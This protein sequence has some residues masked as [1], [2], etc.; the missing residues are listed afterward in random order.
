MCTISIVHQTMA[1]AISATVGQTSVEGTVKFLFSKRKRLNVVV[2]HQLV[3]I[4][5]ICDT[6]GKRSIYIFYSFTKV[7]NIKKT[8]L[9]FNI[10]NDVVAQ[11]AT[12]FSKQ[13]QFS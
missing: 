2:V 11:R 12:R 8:A 5:V 10:C 13:G 3:V 4:S 9:D 1:I 6:K 7:G